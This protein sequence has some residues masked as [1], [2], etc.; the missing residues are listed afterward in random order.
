MLYKDVAYQISIKQDNEIPPETV[1]ENL[2]KII[3]IPAESKT[4]FDEI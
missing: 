4:S 2:E 1:I 3:E